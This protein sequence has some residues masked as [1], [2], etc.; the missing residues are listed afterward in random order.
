MMPLSL[1]PALAVKGAWRGMP[2]ELHL[3]KREFPL[4]RGFHWVQEMP[5]NR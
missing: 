5:F 3:V 2:I 1:A 4:L